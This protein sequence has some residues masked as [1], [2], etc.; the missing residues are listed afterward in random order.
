MTLEIQAILNG[1]IDNNGF[2]I[3]PP[4]FFGSSIERI[5]FNGPESTLKDKARLEV[6]YTDY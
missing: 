3:Y 1:D 2:R 5:I 6:T 4:S